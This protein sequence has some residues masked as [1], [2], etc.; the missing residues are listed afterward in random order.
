[1]VTRIMSC[2]G[3]PSVMQQ[4]VLIS[5]SKASKMA[6]AQNAA[7]T[8]ITLAFAPVSSIASSMVLKTGTPSYS[9]PPLPG[10]TPATT[11]VPLSTMRPV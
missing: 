5:K 7:G 4:T 9:W 1:L 3:T 2:T 6:S 10:V 8:K 11:L